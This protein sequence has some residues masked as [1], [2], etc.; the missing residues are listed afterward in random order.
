MQR[1]NPV[2]QESANGPTKNVFESVAKQMGTVPNI[3]ATMA[4][5]VPATNAYLEFNQSLSR[6]SLPAKL[7][8]KI[9]LTVGESNQCNYCLAAHTFLGKGLGMTDAETL[10]A[11]AGQSNDAREQSALAF[12]RK[13]V[14]ERGALTDEDIAEVRRAGYNDS[15]IVEIVANVVLNIFTN[16]FNHVANTEVDFPAT[17]AL[18]EV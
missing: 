2:R 17:T 12:S 13:V 15:E 8:E 16:Y 9:A 11:R 10:D 5:S 1:I 4:N 3:I 6:G 7:R 14:S 18:A